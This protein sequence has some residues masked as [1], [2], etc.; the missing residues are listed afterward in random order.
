M[1]KATDYQMLA[2]N[3]NISFT[4]PNTKDGIA[5]ALTIIFHRSITVLSKRPASRPLEA[6]IRE[7]EQSD[8][9][10]SQFLLATQNEK[11]CDCDVYSEEIHSSARRAELKMP[12]VTFWHAFKTITKKGKAQN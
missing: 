6:S 1:P 10:T 11:N 9:L 2:K 3:H 12:L 5:R 8:I 7:I 4:F